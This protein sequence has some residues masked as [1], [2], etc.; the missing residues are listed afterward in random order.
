MKLDNA[1]FEKKAATLGWCQDGNIPAIIKQIARDAAE[2]QR[3]QTRLEISRL[4]K[5]RK[6][7]HGYHTEWLLRF[8]DIL[9]VVDNTALAI[10]DGE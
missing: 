4:P 10:P 2:A 1:Y 8:N 5:E 3:L 6:Q 9:Y 7:E